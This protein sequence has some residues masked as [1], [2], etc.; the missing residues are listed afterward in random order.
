MRKV[1]LSLTASLDN[2]IARRDGGYDW[3]LMEQ[4][5]LTEFFQSVDVVF[6]G[7]KTHD[8]MVRAGMPSYAGMKN[9]VFSRTRSGVGAGG[10]EFVSGNAKEFVEGLRTRPGK[11]LWLAGGGELV[12]SFLAEGLVDEIQLAIQPILLGD[13]LPLFPAEFSQVRLRLTRC[14]KYSSGVVALNYSIVR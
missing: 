3:I 10:V 6:L 1:K 5:R 8:T 12:R 11:D 13:G 14:H 9:Y 4:D 7:R 2:Y